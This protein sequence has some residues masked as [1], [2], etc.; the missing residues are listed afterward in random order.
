M[1]F[2]NVPAQDSKKGGD[3]DAASTHAD[4]D[5]GSVWSYDPKLDKS[6]SSSKKKDSSSSSAGQNVMIPEQLAKYKKSES[7]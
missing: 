5:T 7:H 1:P 3:A 4:S 2:N 6:S